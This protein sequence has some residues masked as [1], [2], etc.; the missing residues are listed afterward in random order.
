VL[1]AEDLDY[2]RR[3]SVFAGLSSQVVESIGAHA[4]RVDVEANEV[5]LHEG[6]PAKE[7][8]VVLSGTL[9]VV[10]RTADGRE[11]RLATLAPGEVAG[12]MSL[13]DIQPRSADVRAIG[14]ASVVVLGHGDIATI[15]R[16]DQKSY[17]LLV[18]NIAREIS[19]RLRRLDELLATLVFAIGDVTRSASDRGEGDG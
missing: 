10:K 12:E 19:L 8:L 5:L 4:R 15:Y 2:L 1:S 18:L 16:E 14:P 6:E 3:L 13:I 11:A 17:T 9:E 7:M